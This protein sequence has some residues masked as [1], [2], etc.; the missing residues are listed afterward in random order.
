MHKANE[1]V[2]MVMM[3]PGHLS[4]TKATPFASGRSVLVSAV[5]LDVLDGMTEA[6]LVDTC[7]PSSV[8]VYIHDWKRVNQLLS[9]SFMCFH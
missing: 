6:K 4:E 8:T 2:S 1:V 7:A 5:K 9:I 3:T